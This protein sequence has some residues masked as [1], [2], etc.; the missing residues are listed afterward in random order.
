MAQEIILKVYG[1][2][3]PVAP[4]ILQALRPHFPA[5]EH[6]EQEDMLHYENDMLRLA[7]EGIYLDMEEILPVIQSF[8]QPQSQGKIDY[9]DLDLWTLTRHSIQQGL[10]T[11]STASLNSVMDYS[12]H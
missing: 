12:G 1:H 9:I 2:V 7:Y 6:M 5:S 4:E 3:W 11:V 10:M 8:L